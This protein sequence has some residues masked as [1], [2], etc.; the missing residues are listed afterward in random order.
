MRG[1]A[2]VCRWLCYLAWSYVW[3]GCMFL[4]MI[5]QWTPYLTVGLPAAFGLLWLAQ[6]LDAQVFVVRGHRLVRL[7]VMA[8]F[9][10]FQLVSWRYWY[11][12]NDPER[13]IPQ[14]AAVVAPAD[15]FVVYV[16]PVAAGTVPL[17]IKRHQPIPLQEILRLQEPAQIS[18]GWLIGIFMTPVS[19]H[20][21]RAPIT[22]VVEHRTYYLGD[23]LLS[24]LP[25]GVRTMF[26]ARPFETGA[27]YIRHNERET[28]LIRGAFPVYLTRIADPYVDKIVTWKKE[29]ERVAQGER[30]G[31]I[32]MG[33]QTDLLIPRQAGGRALRVVVREG[34]Y[35]NAGS[36]V[37]ATF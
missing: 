7:A 36:T 10:A 17:A 23:R 24:M 13:V 6:R 33:S 5:H 35:V 30:I 9:V 32:K 27:A 34:Q 31:L 29:G 16:R 19:V 25:M 22:G 12:F 37:L 14:G 28:L 20:V 21:N 4:L 18:D 1:A 26:A 15:G 2:Q 3:A 11:F 8:A